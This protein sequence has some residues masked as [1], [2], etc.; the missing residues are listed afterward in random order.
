L[1][2]MRTAKSSRSVRDPNLVTW[3]GPDDPDNPKNWTIGHKWAATLI[4][5]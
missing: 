5:E 1:E 3:N 4:G 2:K